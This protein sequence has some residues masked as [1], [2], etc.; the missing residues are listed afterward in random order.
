MNQ[1]KYLGIFIMICFMGELFAQTSN[2]SFQEFRKG[3]LERYSTHRTHIHDEYAK[4]LKGV[5]QEYQ[6]FRGITSDSCPKPNKQPQVSLLEQ[7][8]GPILLNPVPIQIPHSDNQPRLPFSKPENTK[9]DDS[10]KY[11]QLSFYGISI[12]LPEPN[13]PFSLTSYTPNAISNYWDKLQKEKNYKYVISELEHHANHFALN[14][15][16]KNELVR[17]Y[18]D[19]WL[20]SSTPNTRIIFRHFILTCMGYDIRLGLTKENQ[21]VLMIPFK[22][23]VYARTYLQLGENKYYIFYDS[24]AEE[25]KLPSISTCNIPSHVPTGQSIDLSF[26]TPLSLPNIRPIEFQLTD[27]N[28]S[29]NGTIPE[30]LINMLTH[31]P[32]MPIPTYAAST[33]L[34]NVR[35]QIVEQLKTQLAEFETL[36]ALNK[37]LHFVQYAFH[38]ATDKQQF[39]YEKPFF[40]EE[41]LYYPDCDCEDRS[42]F[43]AYLVRNVLNIDCHLINFPGHECTAVELSYPIKGISYSYKG[44]NYYISDPTFIGARVGMCMPDYLQI[45]PVIELW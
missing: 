4:Y 30:T 22:Q 26:Q 23:T 20:A 17:C 24:K 32:Q 38:Y 28:L 45:Q 34:K 3:I 39:G 43:F 44:K 35:Q 9:P 5:W 10:Q 7:P 33:L 42:I 16:L 29:V 19:Q 12:K 21:L 41:I 6:S 8:A 27:G 1:Q 31:Y 15:W 14:D 11:F 40:L 2:N 13:K 18:T 37:L 36:E 25:K